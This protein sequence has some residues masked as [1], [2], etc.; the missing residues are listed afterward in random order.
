MLEDSTGDLPGIGGNSERHQRELSV[1]KR[2]SVLE[3]LVIEIKTNH[4]AH[5]EAKL[6]RLHWF[7]ITTLVAVGVEVGLIFFK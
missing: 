7:I 3:T 4:L 6:D 1:E 5:I 2:L